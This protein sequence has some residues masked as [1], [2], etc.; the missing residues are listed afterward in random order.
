MQFLQVS[1]L[2]WIQ[3]SG[4]YQ[5]ATHPVLVIVVYT[6]FNTTC[7]IRKIY[8]IMASSINSYSLTNI[9][10]NQSTCFP[11]IPIGVVKIL[12]CVDITR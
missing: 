11:L 12:T 8:Q 10:C 4:I 3:A 2:Y 9:F 1:N 6:I 7:T 5:V